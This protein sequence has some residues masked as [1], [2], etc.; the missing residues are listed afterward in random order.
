MHAE[1]L[2]QAL[3][4]AKSWLEFR[5]ERDHAP[6]ISVALWHQDGLTGN[7]T[8]WSEAFGLADVERDVINHRKIAHSIGSFS[9]LFT[10]VAV[11]QLVE[12]GAANL[13]DRVID[14]S[15]WSR[16][17]ID[18]RWRSVTIRQLMT[19]QAGLSRDGLDASQWN[20]TRPYPDEDQLIEEFLKTRLIRDPNAA[21]DPNQRIKYSNIGPS[22]LGLVIKDITGRSYKD[23]V[24]QRILY[25]LGLSHTGVDYRP[26]SGLVHATGYTNW[27]S[28]MSII[29]YEHAPANAEAPATGY[30]STPDDM[31][32]FYKAVL[33]GLHSSAEVEILSQASKEELVKIQ[34]RVGEVEEK[35][36]H[37][38]GLGLFIDVSEGAHEVWHGGLFPGETSESS[39]L[40]SVTKDTSRG[41][42]TIIVACTNMSSGPAPLVVGGV[43]NVLHHF[44]QQN[45]HGLRA[46]AELKRRAGRQHSSYGVTDYVFH[47]SKK[48]TTGHPTR[49]LP[50]PGEVLE[51]NDEG[52]DTWTVTESSETGFLGEAVTFEKEADGDYSVVHGGLPRYRERRL[53]EML[54]SKVR[55]P[56]A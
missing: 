52:P 7:E 4:Y 9:K 47:G 20:Y 5:T 3:G 21:M 23:F 48:I 33:P 25:P 16:E 8:R 24:E 15:P 14:H 45:P 32:T 27:E 39:I 34:G 29:P 2:N 36:K 56:Q 54:G 41:S 55:L 51:R 44:E 18:E 35:A 49:W 28:T 13:D 19:H 12:D 37:G 40:R 11:L 10:S 50:F 17:H 1:T 6:G 22:V 31:V 53:T 30:Y 42:S 43:K 26:D 46:G 38:Y